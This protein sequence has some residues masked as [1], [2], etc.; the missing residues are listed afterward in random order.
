MPSFDYLIY[1]FL[2]K[3]ISG[4]AVNDGHF[5]AYLKKDKPEEEV[6]HGQPNYT[7]SKFNDAN[8]ILEIPEIDVK[9]ADVFFFV[10]VPLY[11]NWPEK[12]LN[13]VCK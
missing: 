10:Q 11:L 13:N 12:D 6:V 5:Y 1:I 7:W 2:N 8:P 9:K 4:G 3:K